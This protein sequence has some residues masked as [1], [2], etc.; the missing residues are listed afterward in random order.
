MSVPSLMAPMRRMSRRRGRVE[1]EGTASRRRL[2]VPEHHTDLLP[3]LVREDHGGL[4]S[5]D[6]TGQLAQCLA[7]ESSLEAHVG[8]AHLPFDL[9]PRDEGRHRVHHDHVD[10]A[11]AN[12]DLGDLER[13][14]ARVGLGYEQVVHVHSELLGVRHVQSVLGVHEGGDPTD[15]LRV[16]DDVQTEGR[17]TAR[18]G[19]VDLG[20]PSSRDTADPDGGIQIDGAG[21]DDV[22]LDPHPVIPHPHDGALPVG[23]LDL[24]DGR[25]EGLLLLVAQLLVAQL[26][27]D[28]CGRHSVLAEKRWGRRLFYNTR[29]ENESHLTPGRRSVQSKASLRAQECRS[30][31]FARRPIRCQLGNRTTRRRVDAPNRSVL[32]RSRSDGLTGNA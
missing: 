27:R 9:G 25:G 12:Q 14:L 4:G 26:M 16:G 15:R 31:T 29:R 2:R 5:S 22:D 21:A 24:G 28:F 1:L 19:A 13:L 20:D 6:R 17:L 10:G 11:A 32:E 7:H 30:A 8:V 23:T 3:D 18:F